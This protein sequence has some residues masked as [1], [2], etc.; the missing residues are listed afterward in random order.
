LFKLFNGFST[1]HHISCIYAHP[2]ELVSNQ[3]VTVKKNSSSGH[4]LKMAMYFEKTRAK[5][6][7]KTT[8]RTS[9][10]RIS[11]Q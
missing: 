1:L 9:K 3:N 8:T 2:I 10:F 5:R 11:L 6:G 7:F 4:L